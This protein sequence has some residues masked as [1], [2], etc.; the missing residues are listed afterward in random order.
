MRKADEEEIEAIKAGV[1]GGYKRRAG[2]FDDESEAL[3]AAAQRR[4]QARMRR[5]TVYVCDS[6][7]KSLREFCSCHCDSCAGFVPWECTVTAK[8]GIGYIYVSKDGCP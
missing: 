4:A 8:D 2:D 7:A 1:M 3:L 5:G 6:Y